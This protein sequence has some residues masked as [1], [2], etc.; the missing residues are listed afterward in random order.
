[1]SRKKGQRNDPE[2][3]LL[4]F[5]YHY[6]L[7]MHKNNL[8]HTSLFVKTQMTFFSYFLF[9]FKNTILPIGY[10]TYISH[11]VA[12]AAEYITFIGNKCTKQF[13]YQLLIST[14]FIMAI[15]SY[16]RFSFSSG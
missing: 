2:Y 6:D 10:I 13:F 12:K 14:I 16:N 15:K 5:V 11:K 4:G 3:F 7:C 1:M 9:M 8:G